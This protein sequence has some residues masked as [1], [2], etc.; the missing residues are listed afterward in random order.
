M[1]LESSIPTSKKRKLG[2]L[3]RLPAWL[4]RPGGSAKETHELKRLLRKSALNTVCEEA[5]CPNISECFG[6][7]TAT[8]MILGD[9]CTRGCRFCSVTTGKPAMAMS[10]FASE[11]ERVAEAAERLSL[12][13]VVVTS[14]ARDDLADGGASGFV[15]TIGAVK[16]RL[17]GVT[18]EVLVPDFRGN[19]SSVD[20][21]LSANPDVFNHNLE[22]VPRL[23]R[24]VRPGANYQR[25]LDVLQRAASAAS[26]IVKTGVMLGLGERQ[27]ELADLMDDCL[28]HGVSSFTA[29][30]YM[31]PSKR[32]L[33]V[34]EY[35]SPE[36]FEEIAAIARGKGF[37]FVAA[38]PLVRSSYNAEEFLR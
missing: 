14:V 22:T 16:R 8:F 4:K 31:R 11:G 26:C 19:L 2:L 10:E 32:H 15:E 5:R 38:A 1:S 28:S 18:I 6:R 24:R 21:I 13:H 12:K 20:T 34:A 29:G 37:S 30:Q 35:L 36:R 25:S 33:P 9:I 27:A 23:Y 3:E 17:P 7:G